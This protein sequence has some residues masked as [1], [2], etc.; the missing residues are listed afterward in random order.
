M[1]IPREG[2]AA[3]LP[4]ICR[5]GDPL[6]A[7][8]AVAAVGN[9]DGVHLGHARLIEIARGE[10]ARNGRA[11]AVL[12]F[13]PHPREFF[14]PDDP[15]FRLTPEPVRLKILRALGIEIVFVRLFDAELAGTSAATF[16]SRILAEELGLSGV[17]VGTDFH[18]GRGRE[19]TATVLRDLA[20]QAGLA[21]R[22]A[23]PVEQDGA[24]VSSSR[25]R[26]TLEAGEIRVA[27]RLLGH[28]WF[29]AG[30]VVH[31]EKRGRTLGFPTANVALPP[32]TRLAHGIYAVRVAVAPGIIHGG[33]AS[34][35][36]R[37][38]FDNGAPLLETFLFDFSGDLYG[39]HIEIEFLDWIR[40]E[41]RFETADD[42]V[43]AMERDADRARSVIGTAGA[44]GSLIG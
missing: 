38:T 26:T 25:I 4:L 35:G 16:V 23:D 1:T 32:G 17:V 40:G 9:F 44:E 41:E 11:A 2:G 43:Q 34:F 28:R 27:N 37:P 13:E 12:T 42:L 36:R 31:G 5:D 6:P 20:G 10:A 14:R 18:F 33:V 19:G 29:V 21:A 24:P 30:E 22:F 8:G 15:S 3:P 7:A 39:R